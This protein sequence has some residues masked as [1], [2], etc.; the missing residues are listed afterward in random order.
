MGNFISEK[1]STVKKKIFP[2]YHEESVRS[3]LENAKI[4]ELMKFFQF[5]TDDIERFFKIFRKLDVLGR[6][7]IDLDSFYTLTNEEISS[8]ITPYLERL[9]FLID[10]EAEDRLNFF[11]WIKGVSIFNVMTHDQIVSFVFNMI[12]FASSGFISKKIIMEFLA[13]ERFGKPLFPVNHIIAVDFLELERSDS[14][15]PEQFSKIVV[16]LPFLIYPAYRLQQNL[17][18]AMGGNHFWETIYNKILAAETEEQNLRYLNEYAEGAIYKKKIVRQQ[19]EIRTREFEE[20]VKTRP[21][22]RES[23]SIKYN[24]PPRENGRRASDGRIQMNL[25]NHIPIPPKRNRSQIWFKSN[26]DDDQRFGLG[27]LQTLDSKYRSEMSIVRRLDTIGKSEMNR[28][29]SRRATSIMLKSRKMS[30]ND[31]GNS[32]KSMRRKKSM[33]KN[34]THYERYRNSIFDSERRDRKGTMSPG[35]VSD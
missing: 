27:R 35:D 33:E 20:F 2:K 24:L 25:P 13:K 19:L 34:K 11:E 29:K 31:T 16:Q 32:F 8:I 26:F 9:Y 6:G 14:I 5:R 18:E 4:E 7:Y 28:R 3:F 30:L 23:P 1:I 17:R 22:V 12:D 15:S 10:K 21:P